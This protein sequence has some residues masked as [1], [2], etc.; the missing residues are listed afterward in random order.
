[1]ATLGANGFRPK[2][3]PPVIT[4]GDHRF[5]QFLYTPPDEFYDV[6]FDLLLAETELQKSAIA[7]RV[8]GEVPDIRQ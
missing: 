3:T 8:P 4:I 7:R 5:I 2:R 1:L 6:Q